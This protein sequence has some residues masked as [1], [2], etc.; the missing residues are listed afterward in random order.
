MRYEFTSALDQIGYVSEATEEWAGLRRRTAAALFLDGVLLILRFSTHV[1]D[2]YARS[3]ECARMQMMDVYLT[4]FVS[5]PTP[6]SSTLPGS[7]SR[8]EERA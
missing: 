1:D 7:R 8:Q 5:L 2:N 4:H 6:S 3:I